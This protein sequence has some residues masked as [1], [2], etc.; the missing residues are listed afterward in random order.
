MG[1]F[2]AEEARAH[3]AVCAHEQALLRG[4]L[5]L[6]KLAR[7]EI[8]KAQHQ[9]LGVHDELPLGAVQDLC[10]KYLCFDAHRPALRRGLRRGERRLVLVAQGQVQDE[11]EARAQ[12]E[13]FELARGLP[14]LCRMASI[15][16][17]APRGRP[18]TPTAAR[19]G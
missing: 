12:P 16:T 15:S 7:I 19:A 2:G 3:F 13:F 10:F 5:K 9:S 14:P 1:H 8:E 4:A 18:A 6:L 11:V 17:T